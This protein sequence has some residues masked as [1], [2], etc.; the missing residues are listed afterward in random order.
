[1][2]GLLGSLETPFLI[3]HELLRREERV[4]AYF[5]AKLSDLSAQRDALESKTEH[6]VKEVR[7]NLPGGRL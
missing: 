1:M 4:Q 7:H 6:Y 3:S 2:S 5:R